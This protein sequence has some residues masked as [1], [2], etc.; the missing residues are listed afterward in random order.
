MSLLAGFQLLLARYSG[1][2]EIAVGTPVAGRDE[3][4]LEDLI[5]V[6]LNTLV[7]KVD[8]EG[9][10]T[11]RDLLGRVRKTA[12]GAYAHQ[13]MPFEKL[14]EEIHPERSLSHQPLFQVWFV[15]QNVPAARVDLADLTMEMFP[16][17]DG[18]TKFDLM[19]SMSEGP[20]RACRDRCDTVLI[21]LTATGLNECCH[22]CGVCWRGW[23]RMSKAR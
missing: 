23:P 10:L 6:F 18:F 8:V 13:D 21:S 5:G 3:V 14:V 4:E 1:Q 16:I 22:T 11:V 17:E 2:C 20:S 15:L 9:D 12:L 19:L 7:I